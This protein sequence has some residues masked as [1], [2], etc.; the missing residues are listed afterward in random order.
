MPATACPSRS[1]L[2]IGVSITTLGSSRSILRPCPRSSTYCTQPPHASTSELAPGVVGNFVA[3]I[4]VS[5]PTGA[6][7][8]SSLAHG[9]TYEHAGRPLASP[10]RDQTFRERQDRPT[11]HP[12]HRSHAGSGTGPH[13]QTPDASRRT[14]QQVM[15]GPVRGPQTRL[16]PACPAEPCDR[17]G[18]HHRDSNTGPPA[19][20][21][22]AFSSTVRAGLPP[23][24]DQAGSRR[25]A[26]A[27]LLSHD[28]CIEPAHW[29]RISSA[30]AT[31]RSRPSPGS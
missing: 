10:R 6:P 19:S 27:S 7:D 23:G 1:A 28:H 4:R 16:T 18:H 15:T 20:T 25:M 14:R 21:L 8:G 2:L 5:P 3:L 13:A 9:L 31:A 24:Q 29:L 11:S 22:P 30:S 17:D 26:R 12:V